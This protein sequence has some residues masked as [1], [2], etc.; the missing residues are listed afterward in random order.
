MGK[1]ADPRLLSMNLPEGAA[2]YAR[3][4]LDQAQEAH[5]RL[6][7]RDDSE[8]LH[9]FRVAIRRLRSWLRAY[10]T[11]FPKAK[12]LN[13][14]L[15]SLA[16]LTNSP[17]DA[18]VAIAWL[19]TQRDTLSP[20]EQKG[21]DWLLGILE[22]TCHQGYQTILHDLP[23]RWPLVDEQATKALDAVASDAK[24]PQPGF[25]EACAEQI[26]ESGET[27]VYQ[28]RLAI[29]EGDETLAHQARISAKRLRYLVEPLA[30]IVRGGDAVVHNLKRLQD[31]LGEFHDCQVLLDILA[32]KTEH[33]ATERAKTLI[34][35]AASWGTDHPRYQEVLNDD[36]LPGLLALVDRTRQRARTLMTH[37]RKD[38][39]E[40]A[41]TLASHVEQMVTGLTD[42]P[43][44]VHPCT[45]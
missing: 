22:E 42:W 27:L 10:Q 30:G 23:Q 12:K 4:L 44:P 21:L 34:T 32:D 14:T 41:A 24:T 2:H 17:R 9:D 37:L 5:N 33:V 8:A 20:E 11:A 40:D 7:P 43:L 19:K 6:T 36:P 35:L 29:A 31:L 45:E 3:V 16:K 38:H 18:E 26:K 28:L 15:R 25:A 13:K 1:M 39:T